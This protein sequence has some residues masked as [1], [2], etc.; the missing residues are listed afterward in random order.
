LSIESPYRLLSQPIPPD[1]VS[2]ATL[3][4]E[5]LFP[6][7]IELQQRLPRL[8]LGYV[9]RLGPAPRATSRQRSPAGEKS[10]LRDEGMRIV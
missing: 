7:R 10:P 4:R 3:G 5:E 9:V 2:P 8:V 6:Q 1:S